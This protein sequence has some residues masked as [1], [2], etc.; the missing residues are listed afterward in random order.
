MTG[1]TTVVEPAAAAPEITSIVHDLRNPLSTIHGSAEM[2]ISSRLSERQVHRIA[3]NLYGASVRMRGLLDEILTR[4]RG[5]ARSLEPCDLRELVTSAVDNV[6]LV[7]EAQ[8]VQIIQ[9]IPDNL[10][11]ILD[12]QRIQRVLIN[13]FVNALDVMPSGGDIRISAVPQHSSIFI[14]VRDTGPG[15]EPEI[16]DRLFQ[17]FATAGKSGGLG[18]GLAFSRQ[19]V[20]DHGGQMW[21][22]TGGKGACF[23]FCLPKCGTAH[24]AISVENCMP[25][26]PGLRPKNAEPEELSAVIP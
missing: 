14:K 20:L 7:A 9:N 26:F 22:E 13:L 10:V 2:L 18:L 19:A 17:P 25:N 5:T 12:R 3:L 16:R 15:I 1:Q 8:S 6:A 23:G 24:D 4:Y 11:I 21:V